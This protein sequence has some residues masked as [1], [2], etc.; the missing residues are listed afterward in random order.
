MMCSSNSLP[1]K[2]AKTVIV[3]VGITALLLLNGTPSQA[4][5]KFKVD[6]LAISDRQ[7]LNKTWNEAL[8]YLPE[9]LGGSSGRLMRGRA[10]AQAAWLL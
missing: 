8:V 2:I 3:A 10:F 7:E 9:E 1:L 6:W 5:D 4:K